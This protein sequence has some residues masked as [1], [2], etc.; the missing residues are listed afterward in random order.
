MVAEVVVVVVETETAE[1]AE[2]EAEAE[3]EEEEE[4]AVEEMIV[5]V[6]FS[7][8]VDSSRVEVRDEADSGLGLG[9]ALNWSRVASSQGRS[10]GGVILARKRQKECSSGVSLDMPMTSRRRRPKIRARRMEGLT[11]AADEEEQED[12]DD[13]DTGSDRG[14]RVAEVRKQSGIR[15]RSMDGGAASLTTSTALTLLCSSARV[16]AFRPR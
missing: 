10:R 4:S 8:L 11:A 14:Q 1:A 5:W 9:E 6:V 16:T 7:G 2:A 3:K 15:C 12:D 13:E